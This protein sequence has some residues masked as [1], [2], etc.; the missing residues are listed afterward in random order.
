MGVETKRLS[1]RD[2][3]GFMGP[4][5]GAHRG[6]VW[7]FGACLTIE[8]GLTLTA[9]LIVRRFI[10]LA[11]GNEPLDRLTTLAGLFLAVALTRQAVDI[12]GA[13]FAA[14]L[15]SLT[16]NQMRSDLTAHVLDLD[17]DFHQQT[18]PGEL[19]E[20]VDGDVGQLGVLLSDFAPNVIQ[21]GFLLVGVLILMG[22]ID[23]RIAIALTLYAIVATVLLSRLRH[24][25][26]DA[27]EAV[28]EKYAKLTGFSE[29]ALGSTEDVRPNGAARHVLRR[30]LDLNRHW[31]WNAQRAVLLSGTATAAGQALF[32]ISLA[33]SLGIGAW[34][35]AQGTMTL[36]TLYLLSVYTAYLSGP[37]DGFARRMRYLQQATASVNRVVRLAGTTSRISAPAGPQ[38]LPDGPL[39]VDFRDLTFAYGD[40]PTV[41]EDLTLHIRAGRSVGLVGRT[42]SGK[43]TL[44]RLIVRQYDASQGTVSLAGTPVG[45]VALDEL[46]T[47]VALV[48]QEVQLF[49]ASIRDNVTLFDGVSDDQVRDALATVG[50]SVWLADREL[51][52]D[53][54][55]RSLSAGE[56]QL[57]ALARVFLRDP[58]VV[59]LDEASARLDPSTERRLQVAIDRLLKN[60]TAL[61]IAH[62]LSTLD[63]VDEI[64]VLDRGHLIEHGDRSAL[65]ADPDS[66]FS[67]LLRTYRDEVLA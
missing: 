21:D 49:T 53:L 55:P 30:F 58:G 28:R 29:E 26:V 65:T 47:K 2:L 64:A 20:R 32:G 59:V 67:R 39:P 46:R 1:L 9:P 34:L 13:W 19:I 22:T 56:S 48:T 33:I 60:R 15:S 52:D 44:A 3:W 35:V 45:Q 14:N 61:V 50:L 36:G 8:L 27:W 11:V 10:D 31:F 18:P 37:I 51:T 54:D 12:A 38:P 7:A 16:T 23:I 4:R 63:R 25:G 43:T 41:I 42:G 17:M 24:L 6:L 40:G 62:R 57:L 5:L 66:S